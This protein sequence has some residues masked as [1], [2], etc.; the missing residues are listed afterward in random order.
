MRIVIILLVLL[1]GCGT[2]LSTFKIEPIPDDVGMIPNSDCANEKAISLW[3]ETR[4]ILPKAMFQTKEDY[5][6]AISYHKA[7]LWRLRYT[8]NAVDNSN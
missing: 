5:N 4:T 8:C 7:A 1:S 2:V 6:R 3:L